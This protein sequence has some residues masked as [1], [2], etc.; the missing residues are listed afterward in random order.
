MFQENNSLATVDVVAPASF[1]RDSPGKA[2]SYHFQRAR[3]RLAT[4]RHDLLVALRLVNR[5]EKE[6]I[7]AAW[8][9]WVIQESG[10]CY[11]LGEMLSKKHHDDD[12]T[13][14]V[15]NEFAGRADIEQWYKNYCT[16]C[17]QERKRIEENFAFGG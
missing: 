2:A 12:E 10:R 3:Q 17:Q 16:S 7:Q 5:V 11:L 4:Y 8:E 13:A 15:K 1:A 9:R 6:V 14:P